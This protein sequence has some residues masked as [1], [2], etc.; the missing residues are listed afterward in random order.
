M[1]G[2]SKH[3]YSDNDRGMLSKSKLCRLS[4]SDEDRGMLAKSRHC[5]PSLYHLDELGRTSTQVHDCHYSLCTSDDSEV[6]IS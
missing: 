1:L 3:C 4:Y 5:G 6:T 2:K